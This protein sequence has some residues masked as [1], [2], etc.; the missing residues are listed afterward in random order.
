MDKKKVAVAKQEKAKQAAKIMQ[1]VGE[2][3]VN[4]P[5]ED[6]RKM[7]EQY[8]QIGKDVD[9]A[10]N[11][12]MD[13]EIKR[14]NIAARVPVT[15]RERFLVQLRVLRALAETEVNNGKKS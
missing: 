8:Y 7:A 5:T 13:A 14:R 1:A 11:E 2:T 12:M 3:V 6:L 9:K 10:Y 15:Q 4:I